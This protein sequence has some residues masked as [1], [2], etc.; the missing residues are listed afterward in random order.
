MMFH[1]QGTMNKWLLAYTLGWI[2]EGRNKYVCM[3]TNNSI[4]HSRI[5]EFTYIHEA[6][7]FPFR[8]SPKTKR[9]FYRE[10]KKE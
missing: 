4:A 7:T 2:R 3:D 9:W 8:L 1:I 6:L 5:I 10:V